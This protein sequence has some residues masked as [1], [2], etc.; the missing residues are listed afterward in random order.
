MKIDK[1]IIHEYSSLL[2]AQA[3]K[4]GSPNPYAR[5]LGGLEVAFRSV[6]ENTA[7][8]SAAWEDLAKRVEDLRRL[9]GYLKELK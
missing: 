2:V 7:S 6:L 9:V 3:Q 1:N 4:E 5:A 8:T